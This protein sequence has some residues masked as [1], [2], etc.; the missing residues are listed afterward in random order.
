MR[1]QRRYSGSDLRV[2]TSQESEGELAARRQPRGPIHG[3]RSTGHEPT[4]AHTDGDGTHGVRR[5]SSLEFPLRRRRAV[6]V[7]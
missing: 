4:S 3:F 7:V 2:S 5:M 1:G 6:W